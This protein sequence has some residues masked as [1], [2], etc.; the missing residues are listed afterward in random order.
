MRESKKES[1]HDRINIVFVA[2]D[3]V[4]YKRQHPPS[5]AGASGRLMRESK[6]ESEHDQI[7]I[8]FVANDDVGYKRQHPPS[9]AGASGRLMRESKNE[10]EHVCLVI[11]NELCGECRMPSESKN[12]SVIQ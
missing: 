1:E 12:E 3:D 11:S 6:K 7:N 9:L 8:V 4:G 2:N 5:L 10:S